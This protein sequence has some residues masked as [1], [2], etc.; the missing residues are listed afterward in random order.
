MILSNM[1]KIIESVSRAGRRYCCLVLLG[2]CLLPATSLHAAD[3]PG[4][5]RSVTLAAREQPVGR[6]IEEL[7]GQVGV[8]ARVDEGVRGTVNGDFSG[9]ASGIFND[10]ASSFHLMM[11]FDGAIAWVYP[12]N[13]VVRELMPVAANASKAVMRS[14]ESLG[15]TDSRNRIKQSDVGLMVTGSSRFVEQVHELVEAVDN[16]R[17]APTAIPASKPDTFED[18]A[19]MR[20]F[21]LRYAWAADVSL[22]VGGQQVSLPGV[23]TVLRQLIE[24]G[25]IRGVMDPVQLRQD[26]SLDGL[27]G[28]GLQSAASAQLAALD[29]PLQGSFDNGS[30]ASTRIVADTL[31][32]S[33]IVRDRADRMDEYEQL[34]SALDVEPEMIEIEATIIDLNTDRLRDLGINWRVQDE[35]GTG[36]IFGTGTS[37]DDSLISGGGITEAVQGGVI[38]L[39]L[40][41]S[42]QFLSRIRAL[43]VEGAARVVSKPHVMTLSNVEALLNTTSTFFVRVEGDEEVDLFDVSVGTTLRVTPHVFEASDGARIRLRVNIEDGST[44]DQTVDA[45]PIIERSTINTQ[46]LVNEGESLLIGGLVREFDSDGVSKVPVLGSIPVLGALFRNTTQTSSRVERMFLIT[47]RV[48][49]RSRQGLRYNAPVV[50]GRESEIIRT[51]PGRLDT[52]LAGIS[53]RDDEWPLRQE[54]PY[55]SGGPKLVPDS[56]IRPRDLPPVQRPSSEQQTDQQTIAPPAQG[57]LGLEASRQLPELPEQPFVPEPLPEDGWQEVTGPELNTRNVGTVS[58]PVGF[59]EA[60][61]AASADG[62]QEI[63]Q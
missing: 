59:V 6:F 17:V 18:D 27:R 52:T 56:Q 31:G 40:G 46:A 45:I 4:F 44:T 49:L 26:G 41:D 37:A 10:I 33:V 9:E 63:T 34:I 13:Q 39:V 62:W 8:P 53:A 7:L 32:N 50:A 42:T 14:A 19:V 35:G 43:E 1:N 5:S 38:S 30:T 3:I 20:V 51:A 60:G 25:A 2:I 48:N 11:Y 21:K 54:L 29:S 12:T 55:A 61:G 16:T 23:A 47:P 28:Q 36:A 24:P 22:D 58:A 15:M 57:N